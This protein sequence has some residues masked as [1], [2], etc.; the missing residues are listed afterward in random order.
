M[1]T[2]LLALGVVLTAVNLLVFAWLMRKLSKGTTSFELEVPPV[3]RS[4]NQDPRYTCAKVGGAM[5]AITDTQLKLIHSQ[6][7]RELSKG[8]IPIVYRRL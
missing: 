3:I 2:I 7:Q 5:A 1:E 6:W 8:Y 4:L